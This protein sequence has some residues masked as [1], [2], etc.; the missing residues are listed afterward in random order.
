MK[1]AGKVAQK[2]HWII[3]PS[4]IGTNKNIS[5]PSHLSW[6]LTMQQGS[7][8]YI[9]NFSRCLFHACSRET[10]YYFTF[11]YQIL[12]HLHILWWLKASTSIIWKYIA[13][14]LYS[15]HLKYDSVH[16]LKLD[17]LVWLSICSC[18][19]TVVCGC[20]V[21]SSSPWTMLISQ[22]GHSV[23]QLMPY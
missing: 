17:S 3:T 14:I 22:A 2:V 4:W 20:V 18:I 10:L 7:A 15:S 6:C 8:Q 11:S 23:I 16:Q 5:T 13:Q 9:T 19:C 21:F 12:Y 1:I